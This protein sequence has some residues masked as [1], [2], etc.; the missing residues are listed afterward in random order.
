MDD[1]CVFTYFTLQVVERMI[2]VFVCISLY[3]QLSGK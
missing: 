3:R 1:K 2:I